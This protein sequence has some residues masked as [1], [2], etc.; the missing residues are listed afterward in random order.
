MKDYANKMAIKIWL[1]IGEEITAQEMS[2]RGV[3]AKAGINHS[4]LRKQVRA[5]QNGM[6]P[7]DTKIEI[8]DRLF[9]ALGRPMSFFLYGT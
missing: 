8:F 2:I 6:V 1:R 4:L 5:A 7:D 9:L 3:S